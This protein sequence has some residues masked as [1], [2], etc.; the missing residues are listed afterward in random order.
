MRIKSVEGEGF[1]Q[2]SYEEGDEEATADLPLFEKD[3]VGTTD[4]RLAV[5]LGRLNYLRLDAD[6]LVVLEKVPQLRRTDL[7]VRLEQGSIYL[8]IENLDREKGIEIQTADCGIFLLDKGVY[9]VN[10]GRGRPDRSDRPGRHRRSG[11]K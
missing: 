7:T 2:R 6:S 11:R 3:T 10:S 1:V 4:G 9:R 5:Y 8:D